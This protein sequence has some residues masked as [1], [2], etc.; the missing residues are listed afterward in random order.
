[1]LR[2]KVLRLSLNI[3]CRALLP[4]YQ[5]DPTLYMGRANVGVCTVNLPN[6][7]MEAKGDI[8]KFF[9]ILED[10][11]NISMD[12]MKWRYDRLISM[13][14]KEA[15]FSFVGGAFGLPF[16]EGESVEKAYANG[17]GSL[18]VGYIGLHEVCIALIGDE[19][20]FSEEAKQL[21]KDI[22]IKINELITV[23]KQ[24]TGLGYGLYAT[25]SESLTDR[26]AKLDLETFGIIKGITDK[27]FYI[28]SFHVNTETTLSP[29]E[30]ID[31]EAELQPLSAAGHISY[32][33]TNNLSGNLEA[34]ETLLRYGYEKGLMHQAVNS[35]W[36]FC[37]TCHWTGELELQ[38]D[39][40]FNYT[41]PN[42][43]EGD[44][45][46]VILTRR[47]C[48]YLTTVNKR[49]PVEG[50]MKEMCSRVKHK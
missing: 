12:V 41:C 47:L 1:M 4:V 38:E 14:A 48:G 25:P 2:G 15:E 49:A 33:E 29:F 27:G 3:M 31:I 6:A 13:K 35:G 24:S 39:I 46:Q 16:E 43:G 5:Q 21:Q 23:R 44:K 36:D 22:L 42:C 30:K 8:D 11:V 34:Y 10:R 19:P 18:S 45:H 50:R 26:F 28:N 40:D 20:Y 37:K 32:V 7:A 17:R 9:S